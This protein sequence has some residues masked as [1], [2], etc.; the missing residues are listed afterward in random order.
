MDDTDPETWLYL[1]QHYG[2]R[3][4]TQYPEGQETLATMASLRAERD[5]AQDRRTETQAMASQLKVELESAKQRAHDYH[6]W[7]L[8]QSLELD[9]ARRELAAVRNVWALVNKTVL[10]AGLG[11]LPNVDR[12]DAAGKTL[13]N[14]ESVMATVPAPAAPTP[15]DF[16]ELMDEVAREIG[17][18]IP[19][20]THALIGNYISRC[21]ARAAPATEREALANDLIAWAASEQPRGWCVVD[22]DGEYCILC[23]DVS[24]E[25][26]RIP[27][28][29]ECP[30]LRAEGFTQPEPTTKSF[31]GD[32][33]PHNFYFGNEK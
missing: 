13:E 30:H 17:H 26:G 23:E 14:F 9:E 7:G 24:D 4:M 25:R 31:A 1:M 18:P 28:R 5:E 3:T 12:A 33:S 19:D 16:T 2:R 20:R 15:S 29:L 8:K 21:F 32:A 11:S 22:D 10:W 27:H 6:A